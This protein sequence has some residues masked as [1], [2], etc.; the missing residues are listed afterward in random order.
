MIEA[1][2]WVFLLVW[3]IANLSSFAVGW[4]ARGW[5]DYSAKKTNDDY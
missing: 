5:V 3:T 4:Y 1:P 2:W